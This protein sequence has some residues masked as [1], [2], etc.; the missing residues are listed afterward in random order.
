MTTVT[1]PTTSNAP[2]APAASPIDRHRSPVESSDRNSGKATTAMV[3]G[4]LGALAFFMPIA[5]WILGGIAIG[6]AVTAR[7]DIK[8]HGCRGMARANAGLIL[9]IIAL[10]LG[11]AMFVLNIVLMT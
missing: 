10:A 8:R 6:F 2:P 4:I 5:A 11:T 3:L 1:E 7:S 9:G